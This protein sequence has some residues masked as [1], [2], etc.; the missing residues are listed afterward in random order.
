MTMTMSQ[1]ENTKVMDAQVVRDNVEETVALSNET[2]P[3]ASTGGEA[4]TPSEPAVPPRQE[5]SSAEAAPQEPTA[6]AV[7]SSSAEEHDPAPIQPPIQPVS[8]LNTILGPFVFF[9]DCFKFIFHINMASLSM[10]EPPYRKATSIHQ[11]LHMATQT[12]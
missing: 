5:Q 12:T 9:K 11:T 7:G 2:A 3:A 1:P 8:I 6:A 4:S 10:A